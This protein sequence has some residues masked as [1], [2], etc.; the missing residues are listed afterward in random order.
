MT[1]LEV[2]STSWTGY[3]A[4][5]WQRIARAVE[6]YRKRGYTYVE[7]PWAVPLTTAR[8]TMPPDARPISIA[9]SGGETFTLVGSAEQGFLELFLTTARMESLKNKPLFSVSPCFRGET[10]LVAGVT[11]LCFMKVEL[12]CVRNQ[13]GIEDVL[14]A[15]AEQF[16]TS[17]GAQLERRR[18]AEGTDLFC[19]KFEVGSYGKRR[20]SGWDNEMLQDFQ[21]QYGTGLAEPRF[22]T[23]LEAQQKTRDQLFR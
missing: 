16:M 1:E 8:A 13:M 15:D 17:E 21:W 20:F 22:S 14:M 5:N 6:F 2:D 11:Q 19:G 7:V 9:L 10:S 18:T 3:P 23:A 12:F 4:T